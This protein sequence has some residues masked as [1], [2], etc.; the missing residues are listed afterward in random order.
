[1]TSKWPLVLEGFSAVLPAQTPDVP[2]A[3]IFIR[4]HKTVNLRR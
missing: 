1:L 2:K 3:E 4:F